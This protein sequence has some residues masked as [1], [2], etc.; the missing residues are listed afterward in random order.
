MMIYETDTN[1]VR[2]WNG[3]A[4][5][6]LAYSDYTSGSVLQTV[7]TT[8]TDSFS[9]TLNAGS[10]LEI[11]GLNVSI[12]PSSSSN[13]VLVYCQLVKYFWGNVVLK[14]DS[15]AIGI[16]DAA[17]SRSRVTATTGGGSN[18]SIPNSTGIMFLDSPATT[19]SVTYKVFLQSTNTDN[20]T[21]YVN[22]SET[23]T[24]NTYFG[25]Y[26]STITAMEIAG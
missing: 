9:G 22:R 10:E 25:R 24:D 16:G 1:L 12:T 11:T 18:A 4:W 2:I 5:K 15:T 13:K 23:D 20:V 8:K 14:R 6:T 17:G 21:V 19:S 3:S 26:I 7:S